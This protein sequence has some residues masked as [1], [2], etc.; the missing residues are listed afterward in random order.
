MYELSL[1]FII[2]LLI[3]IIIASFEL[4]IS[5]DIYARII[6]TSYTNNLENVSTDQT[7][8]IIFLIFIIGFILALGIL[9][10][11]KRSLLSESTTIDSSLNNSFLSKSYVDIFVYVFTASIILGLLFITI[12]LW[13]SLNNTYSY[14]SNYEQVTDFTTVEEINNAIMNT[15]IAFSL[16]IL[17]AIIAF[18]IILTY[19]GYK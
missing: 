5:T 14:L 15:I 9:I 16:S 18:C 10:Y 8:A 2:F 13:L 11:Y 17:G 4:T 12:L 6:L 1:F 19:T 7:L 3:I